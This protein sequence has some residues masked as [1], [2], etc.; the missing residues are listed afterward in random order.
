M[1]KEQ[2]RE[3]LHRTIWQ[4]ANDLRGSVDGWDFKTYVLGMLFY[5]FISENL[6]LYINTEEQRTGNKNFDYTKISDKDAEFGR[7]DTVKEKGFYILPSELFENVRKN[8]KTDANLNETLSKVFTNI[9]NSAKGTDSEDDL[10]GLFKDLDV[11]NDKLGGNVAKRN[12]RLAKILESIGDLKLGDY[13]DNTNDIFG[14]AYEFLMTMYASNAGKSGGEFFTPQEVSELLAEMTVVG[15]KQVNKVYDPCCGSG[16]LLLKFAKVLGKENVRQGFYGQETN[17]TTYNLCRINMFLHDIN[18]EKF[19]IAHGDTLTEP[20]HWDDEPFDCIVSNPPYS[21]K[22]EGD[23][24]PLL[25]NDP[26]FSPAGVLAP[27][28]KADLAFTLHM[29][30]WL[31]T[32]GTAAIV[33]FPGVLYRSGAEQKIRKYLIDNNYIDTVIQLPPDL[34]FGTTIAT[35]VIILKKSKKDNATLFIDASGEF[36]RGGN[37]NKLNEANRKKI[38]NAFVGR[39][40]IAANDYNIAISSYVKQENTTVEVNIEKLNAHIADI[41]TKQNKLRTAIDEIVADLE[42]GTYE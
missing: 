36:V 13:Q 14:D 15:K 34:F 18:Y 29:L 38:L 6:T 20:K 25:I 32:S 26:R 10:K 2:E 23:A 39:K 41:V 28:S 40:D 11:N 21:I 8:A 37:K 42:G 12:E 33:E 31:S 3:E 22:W 1:T 16:S 35:C 4:I 30:S 17:I 27:K 5:R 24:N 7:T 9:E 19:N